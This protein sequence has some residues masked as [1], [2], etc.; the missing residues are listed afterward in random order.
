MHTRVR[1]CAVVIGTGMIGAMAQADTLEVPGAYPTIQEAIESAGPGDVVQVEPGFYHERINFLGK[2]ISVIGAGADQCTLDGAGLGGP[3]VMFASE[4]SS[5]SVLEGFRSGHGAGLAITDPVF[6]VVECGAGIYIGSASPTIRHCNLENNECWGG[7]GICISGGTAT[8]SDCAF[9]NNIAEGHGGGVY[10]INSA[11]PTLTNC[12]FELNTAN[13]GGGMTCTEQSDAELNEC[14]FFANT[15]HNVGGGMYIRSS[16]SP[17]ISNCSFVGNVQITNPLGSGGG[18][19]VYGSGT[20]GGPCYPVITGCLFEDNMVNG[21]GGGM[22]NAYGTYATIEDSVFRG[23]T[24]GRDGGGAACVGAHDPD[25]PSNSIFI[26]C[27]FEEN[28]TTERGGGFFSR[29]SEPRLE[30]CT[31][32]ENSSASGGGVYYFESESV[33]MGAAMIC[34][35]TGPQVMGEYVDLGGNSI[36][37]ECSACGGDVTGDGAVGVDDMLMLIEFFGP[38]DGCPADVDGDGVVGV[39]DI[40]LVIAA[41]GPC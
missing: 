7:A 11:R 18:I 34:G 32:S 8:V 19:C 24:A 40:L 31:M 17:T 28:T 22:S 35:N 3:V 38:C 26:N 15:T 10:A 33:E 21:D 25:V 39:D 6:G 37:D 2:A 1:L 23:N 29:A 41:W 36:M 20:G 14:D 27:V 12:R 9:R 30:G 13:W 16:S 5:A 4:E